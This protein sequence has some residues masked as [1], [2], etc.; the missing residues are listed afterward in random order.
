ME[1]RWHN[2]EEYDPIRLCTYREHEK[3]MY[4]LHVHCVRVCVSGVGVYMRVCVS[5]VGMYVSVCVNGVGVYVSGVGMY[6]SVCE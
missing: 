3:V 6:V 4:G 1:A 2:L 5:G